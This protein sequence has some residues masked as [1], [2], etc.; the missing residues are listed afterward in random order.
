MPLKDEHVQ[1]LKN[2]LIPLHKVSTLSQYHQQLAYC[3][4]QFIQKDPTLAATAIGGL[5]KFWP[6]T[7]CTKELLFINELEELLELTGTSQLEAIIVCHV[8]LVCVSYCL[9]LSVN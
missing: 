6:K 3:M 1:F 8:L 7:S 5:L 4:T 2:V 9:L